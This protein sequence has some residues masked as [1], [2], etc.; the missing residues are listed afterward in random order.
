MVFIWDF[1]VILPVFFRDPM[2]GFYWT[3]PG[4]PDRTENTFYCKHLSMSY[5]LLADMS[6]SCFLAEFWSADNGQVKCGCVLACRETDY[7]PKMTSY[8]YINPHLASSLGYT[9]GRSLQ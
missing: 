9:P 3:S 7:V 2:Q 4:K 6:S 5:H 8:K 1:A